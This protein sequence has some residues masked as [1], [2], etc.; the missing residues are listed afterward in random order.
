VIG[1]AGALMTRNPE[2]SYEAGL[3]MLLRGIAC[4]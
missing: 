2:R 4:S 1:L 3:Q